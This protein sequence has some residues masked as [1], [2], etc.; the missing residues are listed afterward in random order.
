MRNYYIHTTIKHA[1]QRTSTLHSVHTIYIHY[2]FLHSNTTLFV[3][4]TPLFSAIVVIRPGLGA[5][6]LPTH[7]TAIVGV[8]GVTGVVVGVAVVQRAVAALVL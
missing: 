8:A 7:T 5:V 4:A 2:M 3:V 6:V 1:L